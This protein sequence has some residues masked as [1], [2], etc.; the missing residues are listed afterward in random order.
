[1]KYLNKKH[2][3]EEMEQRFLESSSVDYSLKEG[4]TLVLQINNKGSSRPKSTLFQRLS[5]LSLDEKPITKEGMI[6]IKPPP[7]PPP[8]SPVSPVD[9]SSANS[10]T[11]NFGPDAQGSPMSTTPQAA[12][13]DD[14]GDF[15]AA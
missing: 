3:A 11:S 1:M 4:E 10:P 13:D 2:A 15:Q 14:F 6:C 9:K 12:A 7:P 8:L 5:S